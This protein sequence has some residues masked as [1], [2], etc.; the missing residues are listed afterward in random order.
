MKIIRLQ[1]MPIEEQLAY[2]KKL[3]RESSENYCILSSG[4]P[5]TIVLGISGKPE[6]LLDTKRVARDNIPVIRRFSGGGTVIVDENTLFVTFIFNK[7][8]HDFP[9]YPE[10]ILRWTEQFYIEALGIDGFRLIENDY[11]IG[12][13]KCG[14]NAQYLRKDRWLHH[15]SF[16][17]DFDPKNMEYLLLPEKRPKY[18]EDRAHTDFLTS[19]NSLFP[20]KETFF[21]R[22]EDKVLTIS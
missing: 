17:Y 5:R 2:E 14:G 7:S 4:T 10:P 20:T 21:Q 15:T 3:L 8:A 18:R 13:L 9:A 12:N 1:D 16:L 6:K 19:L 22:V 11:A